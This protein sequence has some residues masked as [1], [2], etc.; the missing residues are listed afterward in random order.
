MDAVNVV[1]EALDGDLS[2]GFHS[3]TSEIDERMSCTGCWQ[4]L[5]VHAQS[6]T[7]DLVTLR[8]VLDGHVQVTDAQ[9]DRHSALFRISMLVLHGGVV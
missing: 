5:T 9:E 8:C 4:R 1:G 6:L 7:C 3:S 2:V